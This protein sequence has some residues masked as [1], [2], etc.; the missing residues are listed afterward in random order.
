MK[1]TSQTRKH[2]NWSS[3]VQQMY[4][5]IG[6]CRSKLGLYGGLSVHTNRT[7]T[8]CHPLN[9]AMLSATHPKAF[10]SLD[11]SYQTTAAI[12]IF[13]RLPSSSARHLLA[14]S[15]YLTIRHM[16]RPL[17]RNQWRISP[18]VFP[19]C[20]NNVPADNIAHAE[21]DRRLVRNYRSGR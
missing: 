13:R 12:D 20:D 15:E 10:R 17:L 2:D 16:C 18:A 5:R 14:T 9:H 19:D 7:G 8:S 6:E 1:G 11:Y 21:C 3:R 4:S